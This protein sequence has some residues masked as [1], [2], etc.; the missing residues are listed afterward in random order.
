[1]R[2]DHVNRRAVAE[3]GCQAVAVQAILT[4]DHDAD[5]S[6]VRV[7]MR[8]LCLGWYHPGDAMAM[9]MRLKDTRRRAKVPPI[10]ETHSR[11][12]GNQYHIASDNNA[13]THHVNDQRRA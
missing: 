8:G 7:Q 2:A 1:M 6:R 9:R 5:P 10:W 13:G 12:Q 4:D 11:R 3:Q